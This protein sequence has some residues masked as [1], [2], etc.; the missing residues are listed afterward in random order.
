MHRV[1]IRSLMAFVGIAALS[2]AAI[3]VGTEPWS[4]AM[5]SITFFTMICS[6]LGVALRRG[7]RRIYWSGFAALGWGYLLLMYAPWLGSKVGPY[8]YAEQLFPRLAELLHP[9]PPPGGGM[10]SVPV[11]PLGAATT[12]GA[13][14]GAPAGGTSVFLPDYVRIGIALEALLWA[15][16]GGWIACYFASGNEGATDPHA[17]GPAGSS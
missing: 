4:G 15:F 5:F 17:D 1:S 11:G 7:M 16:L 10:Q 14:G 9:V 6:L 8:L 13:F 12:G 3:V 2:L